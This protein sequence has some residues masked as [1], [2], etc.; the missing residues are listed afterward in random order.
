MEAGLTSHR[1]LPTIRKHDRPLYAESSMP[2]RHHPQEAAHRDE[3]GIERER[4]RIARDLHDGVGACLTRISLL[5]ELARGESPSPHLA[6]LAEAAREAVDSLD[7]IVWA[8]NPRHD[9]LASFIDH[10]LQQ[11]GALLAAAGIRCR[12]EVPDT[13]AT[14]PLPAGFRR[15]VFL[16]IQEAIHN[17]AKHAAPG[18]VTLAIEPSPA[19]LAIRITDDGRGFDPTH[20]DGD[21][22]GNMKN[23][24]TVLGGT[25][26]IASRP[27]K[28]TR[29]EFD[30]PWPG[31]GGTRPV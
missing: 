12:L 16:M 10:T 26:R 27:G 3:A 31:L 13:T 6:R 5:A 4:A 18:E 24:A 28:G 15:Q 22:L 7:H 9:N 8:V 1:G 21:G 25:C 23:R 11:T 19:E 2:D 30:L 14:R 29:V 17:A 20:V